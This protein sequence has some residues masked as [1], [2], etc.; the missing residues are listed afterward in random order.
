ME[1]LATHSNNP[2]T[3]LNDREL[4]HAFREG[5]KQAFAKMY[6]T[7]L[8]VLFNYGMK[9]V[10]DRN[11]V[12][13]ALQE[14]FIELW[15]G[16][17]NL[18]ETDQ[19]KYYLYKAFRR[20]LIRDAQ[21]QRK[22]RADASADVHSDA[23]VFPKEQAIISEEVSRQRKALVKKALSKIS[24]RQQEV[25]NLLY[26]DNYSYEEVSQIMGINVKSVYTI[27]WKAASALRKVLKSL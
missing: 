15:K 17:Q 1:Y 3:H 2:Q 25:L 24:I 20:K 10:P 9:V 6:Q 5:D 22:Y 13:D 8:D 14:L 11:L 4:W 27:A 23:V 7:Y 19:I 18:S 16:R 26:Y 21:M 12:K